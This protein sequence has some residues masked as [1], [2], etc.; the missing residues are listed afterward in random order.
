MTGGVFFGLFSC[1]GYIWYGQVFWA[2]FIGVLML[3]AFF[4]PPSLTTLIRKAAFC[5]F[6]VSGFFLT[7]AIASAF[8]PAAPK[9]VKEFFRAL[10]LGLVYGPC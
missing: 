4:A 6:V 1:G 8:H 10:W 7:E 9:T 3:S 2:T 5:F